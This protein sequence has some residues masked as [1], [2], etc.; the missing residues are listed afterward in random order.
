[1]LMNEPAGSQLVNHTRP[2][3][4][5]QIIKGFTTYLVNSQIWIWRD[6]SSTREVHTFAR[7]VSSETSLLALEPLREA[8]HWFLWLHVDGNTR[9][10]TVV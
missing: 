1:M 5:I 2:A 7:Q 10:F 6:N 4:N 3:K 9:G 8:S